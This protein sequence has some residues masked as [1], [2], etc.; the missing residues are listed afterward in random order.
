MSI[1]F[2]QSIR[3]M[4]HDRFLPGVIAILMI[5]VVLVLWLV[6]FFNGALSIYATTVNFKIR[7]DGMV[8]G[9]FP[10]ENLRAIVPGQSAELIFPP[11]NGKAVAPIKA[12]VMDV[13]THPSEPV[14]VYLFTA[15]PPADVSKG[16]LKILLG[17]VPPYT[18]I[19]DSMQK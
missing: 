3:S 6:W 1:P 10:A 13:P 12:E 14:E 9:Q 15:E 4:N 8:L 19:W 16:Q 11:K 2:T 18:L 7:E 5:G 17:Q